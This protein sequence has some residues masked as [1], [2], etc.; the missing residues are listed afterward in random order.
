MSEAW[1][2]LTADGA[3][4]VATFEREFRTDPADLWN[5][6]TDPERAGRW[7]GSLS[8][9]GDAVTI[10]FA[11]GS[12]RSGRVLECDQPRRLRVV[13]DPQTAHESFLVATLEPTPTGS[14][15][16]RMQQDGFPPL[17]A[18][19]FTAG[20]Q[21]H[22]ELL[23]AL[24][25]GDAT[26]TATSTATP[27]SFPDLLAIYR[28]AEA[29]AVAGWITLT[30]DG[31]QFEL[32]RVIGA[33]SAD[34]WDALTAPGRFDAMPR[35][36]DLDADD[37]AHELTL[38]WPDTGNEVTFAVAEHPDGALLRLRQSPTADVTDPSDPTGRRRSGPD[39]A[40]G[41]HST[42]DA[43]VAGLAGIPLP[44]GDELW[45]AAYAVY[46]R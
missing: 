33:S 28:E 22:A 16:L 46:S 29:H 7:L 41:W 14:T 42:V 17:L 13:L 32:E 9:E 39:F 36:L 43:L 8:V 44:D 24:T 12:S 5:A 26:P 38:R 3:R 25:D 21:H 2:T 11:G 35:P 10:G 20:W 19:L 45:Q 40:A 34:V 6:I 23:D 27:T 18:A 37:A 1:G 31:A 30:D 15:T 4:R